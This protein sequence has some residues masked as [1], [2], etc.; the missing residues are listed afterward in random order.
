MTSPKSG[1][2]PIDSTYFAKDRLKGKSLFVTGAARGIGRAV[3]ARAAR[4]GASVACFDILQN[5]LD[6]TVALIEADGNRA[7]GF[8]GDVRSGLD[9]ERAVYDTTT[10]YDRLDIACNAAGVMDGTAPD[11]DLDL[12][13]D[14]HLYPSGAATAGDEYWDTVM[15][16]NAT[17]VFNSCRAE[18]H[19][20]LEQGSGGSIVNIGSIAGLIGLPGNIAYSAS[21]YAVQG[22]TTS[23][24]LTY[25]AQGIRCN[26]VNMAATD[27]PMV[28]RA[29]EFV[30]ETMKR[31]GAT[32]FSGKP[33]TKNLSLLAANDPNHRPATVW[34]QASTILFLLSDEASN[35]TGATWA[36]DGG[37]T[38]Y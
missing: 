1:I 7:F 33:G 22:I 6:E 18:L 20:L 35:I 26:S 3:A 9:L 27:T 10:R 13:R 30:Q 12:D 36:T 25:A 4:E 28:A 31:T 8:C 2:T 14:G 37:W 5:E 23:V 19:V 38:A 21:K 15:A 24:A 29:M 17:G 16:V 11:S 34:E 32:G